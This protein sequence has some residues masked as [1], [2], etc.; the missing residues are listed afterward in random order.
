MTSEHDTPVSDDVDLIAFRRADV[1]VRRQQRPSVAA[2]CRVCWLVISRID[3]AEESGEFCDDSC[4]VEMSSVS[5]VR[6]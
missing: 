6:C 4:D 3:D 2:S 1:S 5:G